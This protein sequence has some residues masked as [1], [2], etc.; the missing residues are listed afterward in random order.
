MAESLSERMAAAAKRNKDAIKNKRGI[1]PEKN[2]KSTLTTRTKVKKQEGSFVTRQK[3]KLRQ[4]RESRN[5]VSHIL[6]DL[7]GTEH[8]D[9]L[10]YKII[11]SLSSSGRTPQEGKYYVFI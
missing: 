8:P 6:N 4:E 9:D 1:A 5:R 7:I 10:M 3:E 11:G 2:T